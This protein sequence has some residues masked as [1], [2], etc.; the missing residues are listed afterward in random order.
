MTRISSPDELL[1]GETSRS[2]FVL[3]HYE[4]IRKSY[5]EVLDEAMKVKPKGKLFVFIYKSGKVSVTKNLADELAYKFPDK[6][7]IVGRE[8][9]GE[10]KMSLRYDQGHLPE[11]LE[12]ALV[13]IQG[14]GGGHETACG[15]CVDA[16]DFDRFQENIE[17]EL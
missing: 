1:K 8:K 4:K 15:C 7:V 11:I 5:D 17:N 10:V 9:S 13:G 2:R 14:S 12:K 16:E 6:L 3:K